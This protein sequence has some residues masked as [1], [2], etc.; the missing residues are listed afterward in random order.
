M[1]EKKDEKISQEE[2]LPPDV[3][4]IE[5]ETVSDEG[6]EESTQNDTAQE[7]ENLPPEEQADDPAPQFD[8][9][10]LRLAAEYD[11]FRKRTA[12]EKQALYAEIKAQTAAAFLPVYDNLERALKQESTD[13]AYKKGIEMTMDQLKSVLSD[14]GIKEIPALG[15]AFDPNVHN[16]VMHK[17][18][19]TLGEG[20]I[21]AVFQ[22]GFILGEKVIRP[23]VVEV[24]N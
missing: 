18:D 6:Q 8:E 9:Q 11:N 4:V 20:E 2:N 14:L 3:E 22:T 23:A 17:E 16:A 5:T 24:A 21:T 1:S 10:Y 13:A 12:K 15:V 7:E 19:E